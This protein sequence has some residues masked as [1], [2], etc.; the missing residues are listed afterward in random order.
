MV[1]SMKYQSLVA[2]GWLL[3]LIIF[4]MNIILEVRFLFKI[5]GS[6]YILVGVFLCIYS[7]MVLSVSLFA[8]KKFI[9]FST[10]MAVLVETAYIM[11]EVIHVQKSGV[12]SEANYLHIPHH[13]VAI[14]LVWIGILWFRDVRSLKCNHS[15]SLS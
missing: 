7:F 15:S 8:S 3:M 11:H 1:G 6:K 2:R 9:V 4:A 13:V 5:P 10:I 12:W 14:F